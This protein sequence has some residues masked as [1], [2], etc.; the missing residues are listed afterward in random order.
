MQY[1]NKATSTHPAFVVFLIDIS[2]SMNEKMP[3]GRTRIRV[4]ESFLY[5]TIQSMSHRSTNQNVFKPR[6]KVSLL[7]YSELFWNVWTKPID[8]IMVD[9][10]PEFETQTATDPANAF[11]AA[12]L[13]IEDEISTW[14][15]YYL[16]KCPAP[17]VIHITDAEL[18]EEFEDPTIAAK[19]LMSV[20]VPDGKVLVNNIFISRYIKPPKQSVKKWPG[21]FPEDTTGDPFGDILLRI[22][23]PVPVPYI[24]ECK[25]KEIG[26]LPGSVFL[27]PGINNDFIR[28]GFV[29]SEGTEELPRPTVPEPRLQRGLNGNN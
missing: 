8:E 2:A 18:K 9:D 28:A 22:S 7:A 26:L 6:Y 19:E 4:V 27:F 23:S 20:Q 1:K 29:M 13:V 17:M 10:I 14:S 3:D 16:E 24:L 21:Y 15:D 5:E 12:K 25:T 11:R